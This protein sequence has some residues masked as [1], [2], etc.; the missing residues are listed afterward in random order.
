MLC[1]A[2]HVGTRVRPEV[3]LWRTR[4]R[5]RTT[6]QEMDL[7]GRTWSRDVTAL[8]WWLGGY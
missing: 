4:P 6:C 1:T 3:T 8:S 5:D 7:L 2:R